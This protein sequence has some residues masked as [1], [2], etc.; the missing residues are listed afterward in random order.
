MHESTEESPVTCCSVDQEKI[1]V[2]VGARSK[3]ESP[4]KEYTTSTKFREKL[5]SW[6]STPINYHHLNPPSMMFDPPNRDT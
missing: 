1:L 6:N 4:V 2:M 3:Y 5:S